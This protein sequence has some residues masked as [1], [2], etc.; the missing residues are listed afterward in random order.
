MR[1]DADR[2]ALTGRYEI[3]SAD[4]QLP[5]SGTGVNTVEIGSVAVLLNDREVRWFTGPGN[6]RDVA[7]ELARSKN[8]LDGESRCLP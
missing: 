3:D 4:E 5:F 1:L 2:L 6:W 7:I 8:G